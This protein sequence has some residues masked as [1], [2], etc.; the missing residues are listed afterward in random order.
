MSII[1]IIDI[2]IVS[3]L[4]YYAIKFIRDKRAAKLF[5]GIFFLAVFYLISDALKMNALS[6][7]L[8]SI[9]QV[10]IIALIILFTPELRSMLEKVGGTSLHPLNIIVEHKSLQKT[11]A[12]IDTIAKVASDLS[13]TKTGALIVIE[14]STK[15][16]D[17]VKSGGIV[18]NAEIS[19]FLLKNIF[20]D[21][22]PLH[23]GAVIISNNLI[24][25]AGCFLPLSTNVE[26]LD[27]LGTRHRAG[28]GI[29]ENSD[30]VVVIVSEETGIISIA[31]D[32]KLDR[33]F[34]MYSLKTELSRLI[35][36]NLVIRKPHVPRKIKDD[37]NDG[38]NQT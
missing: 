27:G 5:I 26:N 31:V 34:N 30:A 21:K 36:D 32:G 23:D 25:A 17:I 14:R 9:F 8:N 3:I 2:G 10:G 11:A 1:D 35:L 20:F 22:A 12:A 33:G 16:G 24:Q 29:S 28:L 13:L 38:N 19:A 15:L 18:L 37:R 7:I 4:I 6:F